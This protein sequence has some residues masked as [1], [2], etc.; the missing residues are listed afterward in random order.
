MQ[1]GNGLINQIK[2]HS[3]HLQL[4]DFDKFN[5]DIFTDLQ[6]R[7]RELLS[8]YWDPDVMSFVDYTDP[9]DV[10]NYFTNFGAMYIIT[11]GLVWQLSGIYPIL[12][13][14]TWGTVQWIRATFD[15]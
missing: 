7:I 8:P 3:A 9:I 2:I 11:Y 13:F 6:T 12:K 1:F 15:L 4:H 5:F 10:W 14:L